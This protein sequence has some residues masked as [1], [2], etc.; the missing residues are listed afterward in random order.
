MIRSLVSTYSIVYNM[1]LGI[2][3]EAYNLDLLV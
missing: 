2:E 3:L 1:L